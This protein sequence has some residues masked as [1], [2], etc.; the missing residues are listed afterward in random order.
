[1]KSSALCSDI[2]TLQLPQPVFK[3]FEPG[4]G[5]IGDL[6]LDKD[7]INPNFTRKQ[8]L[9]NLICLDFGEELLGI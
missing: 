3:G 8:R 7:I 5:V 6:N 9:N 2:A 1:M 4:W